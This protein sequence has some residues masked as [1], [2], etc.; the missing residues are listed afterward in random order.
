MPQSTWFTEHCPGIWN[1]HLTPLIDEI[2]QHFGSEN[3]DAKQHQGALAA[4][5]TFCYTGS[6]GLPNS[7][8]HDSVPEEIQRACSLLDAYINLLARQY[9]IGFHRRC[10]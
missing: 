10:C 5:I 7:P 3:Y 9:G 4:M 2:L 6:Y 8:E 1:L